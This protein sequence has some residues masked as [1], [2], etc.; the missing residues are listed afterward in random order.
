MT[1]FL[2]VLAAPLLG[3]GR[4]GI[5]VRDCRQQGGSTP[6]SEDDG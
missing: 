5:G 4:F 6:G 1:H 2:T 3:S